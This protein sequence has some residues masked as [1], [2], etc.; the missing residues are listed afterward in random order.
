MAAAFTDG[1][2]S[3]LREMPSGLLNDAFCKNLLLYHS[4]LLKAEAVGINTKQVNS[5]RHRSIS[6]LW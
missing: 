2:V 1:D 5:K 6:T 3:S 4:P